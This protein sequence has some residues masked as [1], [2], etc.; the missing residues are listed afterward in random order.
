MIPQF[1]C[2]AADN[3]VSVAGVGVDLDPAQQV[4]LELEEAKKRRKREETKIE[5]E[6][7]HDRIE[8]TLTEYEGLPRPEGE[9][10]RTQEVDFAMLEDPLELFE[11]LSD[12]QMRSKYEQYI[13]VF[14]VGYEDKCE[15]RERLLRSLQDFFQET[16][17]GNTQKVLEEVAS[18]EIDFDQATTGLESA[19][20]TAQTAASRLLEIK[21]EMGQLFM[22]FA[23]YPDTKKGR[24]KMEKALL[25]AQEDVE[26]LENTLQSVQQEL[27]QSK[28]KCKQLQKQL[29]AKT[30]ENAKL[31]K[32]TDQVKKLEVTNDSLKAELANMQATLKQAQEDLERA[33]RVKVEPEVREVV[34]VDEGK[35]RE[36]E[37]QLAAEQEARRRAEQER[38]E[39]EGKAR[40]ELEEVR[41]EHEREM[42]EMRSRYEEQLRSLV[43]DED[44]GGEEEE[45]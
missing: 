13:T 10:Q 37:A 4:L 31:R 36:L 42:Q 24:K 26:K 40:V 44:E 14:I 7:I 20:E 25:K 8:Y 34:K 5:L 41:A 21:R 19:L 30:T 45:M 15:E 11:L 6:K 33:K 32:T 18:E 9:V 35:T 28:D 29:D 17:A 12:S 22:M 3:A 2:A 43:V 39:V 27:E 16:T 38:E 23:A 1:R